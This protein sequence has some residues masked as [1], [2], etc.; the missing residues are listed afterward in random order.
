MSDIR[1]PK[2]PRHYENMV[3]LWDNRDKVDQ[4]YSR[5]VNTPHYSETCQCRNCRTVRAE[6]VPFTEATDDEINRSF[7]AYR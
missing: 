1:D 4:M 3:D 2:H 7:D 5:K 6:R